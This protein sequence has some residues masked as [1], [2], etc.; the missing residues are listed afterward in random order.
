MTGGRG[1]RLVYLL[2][3]GLVV[4]GLTHVS[5]VLMG[6]RQSRTSMFASLGVM[7]GGT[8]LKTVVLTP[9]ARSRIPFTDPALP[10]AAC[11]FD[12]RHGPVSASLDVGST[13]VADLAVYDRQGRVLAAVTGSSARKGRLG[14]KIVPTGSN[15]AHRPDQSQGDDPADIVIESAEALGFVL[16]ETLARQPSEQDDAEARL[17]TLA[18]RPAVP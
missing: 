4:A 13:A 16:A 3:V 7:L 6:P 2:G 10:S 18:C 9:I 12:L 8:T 1:G 5:A 17:A 14:L 15:P 11:L